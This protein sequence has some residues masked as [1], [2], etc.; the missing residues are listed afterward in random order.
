MAQ[1]R[2]EKITE[3]FAVG[4]PGDYRV[5]AGDFVSVR[6]FHVLTHDNTG[7]VIPKFKSI[8]AT[9]IY[10]PSQ[11]MFA[12]DHDVQNESPENLAKYGAIEAFARQHG[13]SFFP[14]KSGIGHQLM[15]E[16]G[17]V[18][19]GTFVVGSDSHSNAEPFSCPCKTGIHFFCPGVTTGHCRDE[20]GG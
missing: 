16:E 7:A 3:R 6:P 1:N 13:I 14:S 18:L 8:G 4:L 9:K 11:P 5:H 19:P 15:V 10:D 12:L 2:I 20:Q 17:F